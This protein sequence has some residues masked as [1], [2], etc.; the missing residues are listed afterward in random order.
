MASPRPSHRPDL[1]ALRGI[2]ILLVVAYHAGVGALGG[3]FVGVDIFF[4]LSGFFAARILAQEYASSGVV[5]VGGFYARRARRLLPALLAM[6]ATTLLAAWWLL[7]PIDRGDVALLARHVALGTPNLALARSSADYF[8]RADSPF[9]HSWSLGVELQLSLFVPLVFLALASIGAVSLG[10]AR[11][12]TGARDVVARRT[13]GLVRGLG[14]GL[15]ILIVASF[16]LSVWRTHADPV[17]AFYGATSRAWEFAVGGM[18]AFLVPAMPPERVAP[19]DRGRATLVLLGLVALGV[20]ALWYDG[21]MAY[22][23]VAALLPVTATAFAILGGGR[24]RDLLSGDGRI[25]RALRWCARISYAW[26]LWHWPFIAL[27]VALLP[28]LGVWG[29]LGLSVVALGPAWLTHRFV[30]EPLRG[31]AGT[32]SRRWSFALLLAAALLVASAASL[33]HRAAVRAGAHPSQRRFAAAREDRMTHACW[34]RLPTRAGQAPCVFGDPRGRTT[35]ALMGDS[36]AEHWIAA[37]D[38]LGRARGWRVVVFVKGGC[39]VAESPELG[40]ARRARRNAECARYRA[41]AVREIIRL[42]PDVAVLSSWSEYVSRDASVRRGRDREG[43]LAPSAW[44]AGLARTYGRIASRGIPV[45]ALRSTPL[46]PFDAPS[47]LSQAAA[48]GRSGRA[49]ADA[50]RYDRDAAL[51]GTARLA[52]TAAVHDAARRGLPVT[53][54]EMSDRVCPTSMCSVVQRG[55]VAFTDDNHLAASFTRA[56]APELGRRLDVALARLGVRLPGASGLRVAATAVRLSAVRTA[57]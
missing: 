32:G 27:G 19:V 35:V 8:G 9:L 21:T 29:K 5:D 48:R 42:R 4:V 52:Q 38:R 45:V 11:G 28:T 55:V 14:I 50:C 54:V 22:P 31:G 56:L 57:R 44:R 16:A 51:H 17:W 47:C 46:L 30:E 1:E 49:L 10:P 2:A 23:G 7:P 12:R 15:P 33:A 26:Y 36:H 41:E 53:Y 40:V 37:F 34:D 6:V 3:G 39:P 24:G 25:V 43:L 20:A 13:A 18:L